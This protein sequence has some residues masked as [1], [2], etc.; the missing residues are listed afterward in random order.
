M[1]NSFGVMGM[2]V[3][4]ALAMA[5]AAWAQSADLETQLASRAERLTLEGRRGPSLLQP[6]FG[7]GEYSGFARSS[8]QQTGIGSIFSSDSM[9]TSLTVQRPGMAA[10]T[11]ECK[12]GQGRI[13]LDWITF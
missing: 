4:A 1:R 10:V 12:G 6:G 5:G 2:A 8:K 13:G 11:G 7:V 9:S 3:A